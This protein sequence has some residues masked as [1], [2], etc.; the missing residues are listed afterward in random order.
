[1][2]RPAYRYVA[3]VCRVIDGDTILFD[4]DAGF[5]VWIKATVRVKGWNCPERQT[6]LG[7][8]A[9]AAT[10]AIL[11]AAAIV[12]VETE[13][14]TQSFARWVAVVWV[15]GVE[16]GTHLEAMGLATKL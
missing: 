16:L 3:R 2:T 5:N 14:D 15:D 9:T 1:M 12:I 4:V 7:P 8:V 11:R 13:K 10:D 6:P